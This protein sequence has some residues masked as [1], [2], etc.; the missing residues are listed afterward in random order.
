MEIKR[1]L[2]RKIDE[3]VFIDGDEYFHC[4]KV[5]RHK[6]GYSIVVFTGDGYD[7]ICRIT[8]INPLVVTAE[9]LKKEKNELETRGKIVLCL[10]LCKEFDFIVQK[11]VE[12]GVYRIIPFINLRTNVKTMKRARVEKIILDAT[13][14]S[15]R[16]VIPEI[17]NVMSFEEMLNQNIEFKNRMF[18]FEGSN[19]KLLQSQISWVDRDVMVVIGSEGG[20]SSE[21]VLEAKKANFNI[22][23]LGK[24]ILKVE[25]ATIAAIILILS[26]YEEM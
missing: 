2:G 25:T 6:I 9:I 11:A 22:I 21:D 20:F 13:K 17:T 10:A 26:K 16:A 8:E 15:G 12:L 19:D 23:S 3:K 24:R 7:Y 18:C 4:V 1:F 14:Q 5:L